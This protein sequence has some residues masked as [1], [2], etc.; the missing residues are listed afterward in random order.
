M[1]GRSPSTFT[2]SSNVATSSNVAS[3]VQRRTGLSAKHPCVYKVGITGNPFRRWS[4]PTYG[5]SRD[6][7][8]RWQGLKVIAITADSFSASLLETML[9]T[10]F[11]GSPGCRNERPGGESAASHAGPFFTYVLYRVLTPPPRVVSSVSSGASRA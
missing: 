5:Y 4:H 6:R 7:F 1:A 9:I 8:E 2:P 3:H 10:A 11:K